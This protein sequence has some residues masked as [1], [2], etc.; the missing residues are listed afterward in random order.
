VNIPT[1][2]MTLCLLFAYWL[3]FAPIDESV[4]AAGCVFL[5]ILAITCA[6]V[7]E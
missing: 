1:R 2:L 3:S 5:G 7:P 4:K 6:V